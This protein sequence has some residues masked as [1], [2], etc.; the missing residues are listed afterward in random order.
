MGNSDKRVE[1]AVVASLGHDGADIVATLSNLTLSENKI[2]NVETELQN[3]VYQNFGEQTDVLFNLPKEHR[4]FL[5]QNLTQNIDEG[6]Q[7]T[8]E[9]SV[10]PNRGNNLNNSHIG[11]LASSSSSK[12]PVQSSHSSAHKKGSLMSPTGSVPH[13]QN[14]NGDN[15][16]IDISG[17][18]TKAR[19]GSF[20]SSKLNNS[21]N[22][23]TPHLSL[24]HSLTFWNLFTCPDGE[25]G[26]FLSNQGGSSFQG[27]PTETMYAQYLQSNPDSPLGA[28]GSMSPFHRRS[29]AGSGHLDSPGYQ[30]AYLG[31]LIAQQKLQ[32]G[33]PYIGKPGALNP[34]IYCN[35]PAFGVGMTYLT[36]PTS[37][38]FIPSPQGHVRQGERLTQVPSMARSTAG[39][40]MGSW[41]AE[42]S[43]M[44]TG[45]GSSLLEEFKTNK[46]RSFELL[47]IAG[48]VVEFR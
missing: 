4:Q 40:S 29:F 41:N 1:N 13:Y 33:M 7:N 32:Y 23:G 11:K 3:H 35:D 14:M 20:A 44:D 46:T 45:Y 30:K 21:L 36:S 6:S 37:S 8:P 47:D 31:S 43:L 48:H 12:F 10:F 5:Q 17:R 34:N 28:T 39:G 42:N 27:Q 9:Y 2:S 19:T 26:S 16:T 22:S 38:P 15:P 18:H 24:S 25:Y